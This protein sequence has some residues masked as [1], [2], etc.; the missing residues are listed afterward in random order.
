MARWRE[1]AV[2]FLMLACVTIV[3]WPPKVPAGQVF[4]ASDFVELHQRRMA[5]AREALRGPSH[6]LPAWYPRELLGAPFWANVQNFPFLPTRL[7]V[8]LAFD[9]FDARALATAILLAANLSALF[10]FLFMRKVR[11]GLIG[12]SAGA[13][14]FACS[15]YF[16]SRILPG[17]LPLLEVYCMLPLLLWLVESLHQARTNRVPTRRWIFALGFASACAM[18]GGHPQ[19]P[20]YALASAIAYALWR[21]L[22]G[23]PRSQRFSN[24]FVPLL[25]ILLGVGCA[26][27]VLLPMSMLVARSTRVLS[28][29]APANDIAFIYRLIPTWWLPKFNGSPLA[30]DRASNPF[31]IA[32]DAYF[33]DTVAYAGLAPWI[34]LAG[35]SAVAL[36]GRRK[37]GAVGLFIAIL[38]I[39]GFIFALPLMDPIRHTM[40]GVF[41]R[42]PARLI[43]L[44]EF[45]LAFALGAG[46]DALLRLPRHRAIIGSIVMAG[47]IM[48]A[49][50][51]GGFDRQFIKTGRTHPSPTPEQW[52]DF[53]KRV[54]DGRAGIDIQIVMPE[55]RTID[56]VG[57]FDSIMLARPYRFIMEQTGAPP[58]LNTQKVSAFELS[59]R[60][61][62]AAGVKYLLT[63]H[64][65][66]RLDYLGNVGEYNLYAVPDAAPRARFF[67][68]A[69]IIYRTPDAIHAALR[70][71]ELG[72]SILMLPLEAKPADA[73]WSPIEAT[74]KI[75]YRR[76]DA[77]TIECDVVAPT[78]GF[79]RII[80]SFDPGWRA[81]IDDQP[82]Q[83]WPAQDALLAVR[84]ERGQY[85]IR[86]TYHTPGARAGVVMSCI[87]L[88]LLA[89]LAIVA[90]RTRQ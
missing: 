43:Y 61:L 34:A 52:A 64:T 26:S 90:G 17:H 80:E 49:I 48:H 10:A 37:P 86:F 2:L 77:D 16:A 71:G 54:G 8:L 36:S 25:T 59:A 41:L 85:R 70:S 14:T 67:A 78:S 23:V 68:D 88:A 55:N 4:G 84:T 73:S 33:W 81:T 75:D 6:T 30:I 31:R 53:V 15:G 5:F 63:G 32:N 39:V 22:I 47:L 74:A 27:F 13:W 72:T 18:L 38:G 66:E 11:F 83:V 58:D 45:A 51:L 76:I 82:A 40:S 44:T 24:V 35:L 3:Y 89:M 60:A 57:F 21:G 50:D 19:L 87:S 1:L 12:A 65:R 79:L 56:D 62:A 29:G 7:L 69:S 28:L 42:S 20:I 9:P 46:V